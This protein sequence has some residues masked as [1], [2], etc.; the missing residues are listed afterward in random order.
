[1]E[2]N[3]QKEEEA[4]EKGVWVQPAPPREA[5]SVRTS[6]KELSCWSPF[7]M[8]SWPKRNKEPEL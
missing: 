3:D 6:W 2:E 7:H 5:Q 1:V 8:R 4:K